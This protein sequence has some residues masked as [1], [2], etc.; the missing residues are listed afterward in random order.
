MYVAWDF[1][2]HPLYVGCTYDLAK[3]MRQHKYGSIW[4]PLMT[5]LTTT[6]HPTWWAGRMAEKDAIRQLEPLFNRHRMVK[7][8]HFE[9]NV[10]AQLAAGRSADE[11]DQIHQQM[12]DRIDAEAAERQACWRSGRTEK[13]S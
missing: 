3:R 7:S 4:Y 1:E 12:I 13:A 11:V 6:D 10:M 8:Y 2:G 5:R 9:T